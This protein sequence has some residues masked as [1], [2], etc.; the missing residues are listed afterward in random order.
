MTHVA[1]L[2]G[3]TKN[4]PG[5]VALRDVSIAIRA[6]EIHGLAGENG[7]GKSTLIKILGGA[8]ALDAGEVLIHDQ[9]V[10][11]STPHAAITR[12]ISVVHQEL[13][14]APSLS[15][16]ENVLLG[17][18]SHNAVGGVRWKATRERARDAL[19]RVGL[20]VDERTE[21]GRLSLGQ[22]QLVEIARALLRDARVLVLDEPSAILG[23]KDL[24]V[25]YDVVRSTRDSGVA[26]VYI[27]HRLK[28]VLSLCD[29]VTVLKD[30]RSQGTVDV[31]DLDEQRLVTMMTGRQLTAPQRPVVVAKAETLLEAIPT[32]RD[33]GGLKVTVRAGEIVGL[34]G[35][36]GSGRT[37]VARAII[38]AEPGPY[39]VTV[40]GEPFRRRSPRAARRAGIA[41]LP[42]DRKDQG[43][44][45]NRSI[46]ENVG[47][48]S[49]RL[50]SIA[51]VMRSRRDR[52]SVADLAK[53]VHLKAAS[54]EAPPSTLSGGNQQKVMLARW[55]ATSPTV[56]ILD[57]PTRGID[58]GG[59]S[60]IYTLMRELTDSGRGILMISSEIEEVV[61][62][63][64]RVL[65]M[66][67]G[68]VVAEYSGHEITEDNISRSALL[69]APT[70]QGHVQ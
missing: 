36:V 37:E 22:Q 4:Y 13:V 32:E 16:A 24:D 61:A 33:S 19:D 63:S 41:Y 27:S 8:L 7:A 64:D 44:L 69:S 3:I 60:E 70:D 11:L 53:R 38:G 51:G 67:Q 42:E 52:A 48:A 65:V 39:D 21:M 1:E 34:A 17:H 15:V 56:L 57:E 59:K 31:T 12:G 10:R 30:G 2:K 28:E 20:A 66:N 6:G 62:M 40:A 43:L 9:P 18:L 14:S 35:L 47:L 54:L 68:R 26:V 55:L 49:L 45:L 25:L 5:V 23:G 58:V 50:R 29:R 46:R